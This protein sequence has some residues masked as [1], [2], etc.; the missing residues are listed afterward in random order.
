[1]ATFKNSKLLHRAC[2]SIADLEPCPMA[3]VVTADQIKLA[4]GELLDI[5]SDSI[6]P[7]CSN[8]G[9]R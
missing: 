8:H 5:W 6:A 3:G 2:Q 9:K 7:K 1:M 4:L